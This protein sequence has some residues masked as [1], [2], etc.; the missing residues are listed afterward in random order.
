MAAVAGWLTESLA[1]RPYPA[2]LL[3]SSNGALAHLAAALQVPWLPGT[4]LVAVQRSGDPQRP[5]ESMRFGQRVATPLLDRNPDI[6]LHHMHD[7]IQDELMVAQMTYFRLKWRSLPAAYATFL[8]ERLLPGAPVILVEDTSTWP[9]VRL[10]DRQVFQSGAQGG[11]EPE[12]YLRRPDTPTPDDEAPEAEWGAE[13]GLADSLATWCAA[14]RHPL[15]RIR[16]LGPQAPAHAVATAIRAWYAERDERHDALV[17]PSFVVGDPWLSINKA[18]VPFWAFFSVQPAL[19]A[20]DAHLGSSPPYRDVHLLLF[21]HGV[22]SA[23]IASPDDWVS[24]IRRHGAT[25]HLLALDR[26]RFPHDIALLGRYGPALAKLPPARRAWTP[27]SLD[28]AL[29]GLRAGGIDVG[30]R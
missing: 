24:V 1:Q 25:P 17:V 20:L 2:V 27:L 26:R 29:S 19:D 16:Y 22:D 6:A 15:I 7:Q 13:P 11:I 18:L 5:E 30:C 4:V 12:N 14:H 8:S 9:V 21:Q 3:G 28:T 23:G 10:G